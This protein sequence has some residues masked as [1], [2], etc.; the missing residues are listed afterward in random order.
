[1]PTT[2][3]PRISAKS[4]LRIKRWQIGSTKAQTAPKRWSPTRARA[5]R[6]TNAKITDFW[7]WSDERGFKV[8][9]TGQHN[10]ANKRAVEFDFRE[11]PTVHMADCFHSWAA[12]VRRWDTHVKHEWPEGRKGVKLPGC[13]AY[14]PRLSRLWALLK[15][16]E[17]ACILPPDWVLCLA[18]RQGVGWQSAGYCHRLSLTGARGW[19]RRLIARYLLSPAQGCRPGFV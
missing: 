2:V 15:Q 18:L 12:S 16:M 3:L 4:T 5:S 1:M 9:S 13:G 17:G 6:S 19:W 14:R 10:S 11:P 7:I 8:F